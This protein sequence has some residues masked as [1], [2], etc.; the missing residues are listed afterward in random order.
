[1]ILFCQ[2]K[3]KCKVVIKAILRSFEIVSGLKVNFHK[4]Q[5]GV[6]GVLKMNLNIFSNCLNCARMDLP[7]KYMGIRIGGN[8]RNIEFWDPIIHKIQSRLSS[9]KGKLLSMARR[10]CLIKSVINALPLF[11]FFIFLRLQNKCVRL[12]G[13]SNLT[14][15]GVGV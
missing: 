13:Q 6:V 3:Y 7:F 1:M 14:F 9:W 8:P 15:C 10:L 12:L 2:P 5:V 4:S 11:Y